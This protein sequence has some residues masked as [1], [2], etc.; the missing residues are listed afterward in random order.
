MGDVDAAIVVAAIL[1]RGEAIS[2]A[3][4]YLRALTDKAGAGTF[5]IGPVL[6]AL[7]RARG[8]RIGMSVREEVWK[9]TDNREG[10]QGGLGI[11]ACR[12]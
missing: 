2:S 1:Q 4:G 6:M 5:S 10:I 9:Q 7:L 12:T 11:L 3:G 8:R